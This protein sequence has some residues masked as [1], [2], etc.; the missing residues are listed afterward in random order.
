MLGFLRL[1]QEELG[2]G[3]ISDL[4]VRG[5]FIWGRRVWMGGQVNFQWGCFYVLVEGVKGKRGIVFEE[6]VRLGLSQ[7]R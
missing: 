4:G 3:G 6:D 7:V 1:A 2:G 5:L